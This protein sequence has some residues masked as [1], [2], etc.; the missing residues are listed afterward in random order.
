[1]KGCRWMTYHLTVHVYYEQENHR[2]RERGLKTTQGRFAQLATVGICGSGSCDIIDT[3]TCIDSG[4][5]VFP[6]SPE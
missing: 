5:P 4:L 6:F 1:M 3:I 2:E